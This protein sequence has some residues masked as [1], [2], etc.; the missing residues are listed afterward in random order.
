MNNLELITKAV[1]YINAN[2]SDKAIE[3]L[4]S[5]IRSNTRVTKCKLNLYDWC[6]FR[7]AREYCQGVFYDCENKLA[8][9]TDTHVLIQSASR[10]IPPCD[11]ALMSKDGK[12]YMVNKHGEFVRLS[13]YARYEALLCEPREQIA[14]VI[15]YNKLAGKLKE[16]SAE[17]KTTGRN[18]LGINVTF[19]K[20]FKCYLPI[21]SCKLLLTLPKEGKYYIYQLCGTNTLRYVYEDDIKAIIAPLNV[22]DDEISSDVLYKD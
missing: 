19:N 4:K 11:Y 3:S 12:G 21:K 7:E 5:F 2:E 14:V 6:N 20:Q 13:Q 1:E 22:S 8:V 17:T 15:D 18:A 16:V 9:A 10:F